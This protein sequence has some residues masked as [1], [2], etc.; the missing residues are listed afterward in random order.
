MERH[1]AL[2]TTQERKEALQTVRDRLANLRAAR[3]AENKAEKSFEANAIAGWRA[4][5]ESL[6]A[7]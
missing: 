1:N 4:Q 2:M 3:E 5:P 6:Q 7:A